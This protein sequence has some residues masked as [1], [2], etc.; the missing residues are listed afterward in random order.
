MEPDAGTE[1]PTEQPPQPAQQA[2]QPA[3]ER[4]SPKS[5]NQQSEPSD[6]QSN[7]KP[8]RGGRVNL[9]RGP[10][11]EKEE[12]PDCKKVLSKRSLIYNTHKCAAK[13]R[14]NIVVEN[15]EAPLEKAQPPAIK[16]QQPEEHKA[17]RNYIDLDCD[18]DYSH[19]NVHNIINGYVSFTRNRDRE[20]KQQRYRSMLAGRL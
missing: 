12:C 7:N 10:L 3:A 8:K 18:I 14:K 6:Q 19:L 11:T 17:P 20:Q 9:N 13:A 16:R 5:A 4:P 2:S 1:P 15:I